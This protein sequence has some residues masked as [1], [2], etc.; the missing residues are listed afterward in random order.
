[1]STIEITGAAAAGADRAQA[2]RGRQGTTLLARR[3]ARTGFLLT[4]P[5]L[6]LVLGLV[7]FPIVF[8]IVISMTDWPLFGAV[9]FVGLKNYLQLGD[10]PVFLPSIGF[11]MLYTAIVTLPV[12]A[13]GYG[14]A[15]FV[16]SNRRGAVIFRTMF[17]LPTVVG[18]STLSFLYLVELQPNSGAVNVVLKAFGLTDGETPWFLHQDTALGVVCALVIWFAGGTTMMLLLGGMQAIPR[19]LYEAAEIDGAN[20]WQRELRITV[21][22]VR[23]NIAMSLVLSV[24]GSFLAFQHFLILTNGGPGS[25][26]TTVVMRVYQKAFV[27]QQLGSASAMGVVVMLGIAALTCIQLFA[28]REKE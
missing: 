23:R 13:I 8:A 22:L 5:A 18:L 4:V 2:R 7:I 21:P 20:A 28:L 9:S 12:L 19:E 3:R 10:D 27:S 6:V 14:L 16:R 17:F 1:V 15:A 11:T 25:S 24:I 26:T